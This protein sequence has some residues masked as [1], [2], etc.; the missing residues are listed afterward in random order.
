M[1]T[2]SRDEFDAVPESPRRQ[3]VHRT[4][5][6]TRA[7][8]G[9]P[10]AQGLRWILAAAIV[11]LVIGAI[12]YFVLPNIGLNPSPAAATSSTASN[13]PKASSGPA[14]PSTPAASSPASRAPSSAAPTAPPTTAAPAQADK[15]LEVGVYNASGIAGLGTRAAA[16]ARTTG[17][18]VSTVGNWG[19]AP[20]NASVVYYQSAAQAASAK[21]LAA[22]VGIATVQE[23]PALGLPLAVVVGPGYAG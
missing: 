15:S 12:A 14:S 18:A 19:G 6:G 21:A 13:A 22:D 1:N 7:D 17:W 11:A 20:V 16:T 10:S 23:A 5:G 9:A 2:Y 4:R 8:G 3:G